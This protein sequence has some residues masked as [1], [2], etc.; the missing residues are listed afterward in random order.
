M[1]R[2][3]ARKQKVKSRGQNLCEKLLCSCDQCM[4]A[5]CMAAAT[6]NESHRFWSRSR[7]QENGA[8]CE[9]SHH[10]WPLPPTG[11]ETRS[12]SSEENSNEE[13]VASLTGSFRRK[14]RFLGK[15]FDNAVS[16]PAHGQ[17]FVS[18][19]SEKHHKQVR[20]EN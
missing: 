15:P 4:A 10:E 11:L 7:C 19:I 3:E 20:W 17:L 12:S 8:L 13:S 6:F 14:N 2:V 16:R 5:Q 9:D 1:T 18:F